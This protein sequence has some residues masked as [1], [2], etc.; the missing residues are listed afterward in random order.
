MHPVALRRTMANV[1]CGGD[2]TLCWSAGIGISIGNLP[3]ICLSRDSSFIPSAVTTV[4]TNESVEFTQGS[5]SK[6][7]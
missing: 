3:E 1:T 5:L 2:R 4:A 7:R 6:K